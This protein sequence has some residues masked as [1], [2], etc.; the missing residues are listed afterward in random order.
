MQREINKDRILGVIM[1]AISLIFAY[2]TTGIKQT[3]MVGDPGPRLFP[4][5][6]CF[7]IGF[8]SLVLIIRKNRTPYKAYMTW[9]QWRRFGIL[10]GIYIVNYLALYFLGYKVAV[11]LTAGLTCFL[12]S[13]GS[14]VPTWKKILYII[15]VSVV[16]WLVYV[17]LLE[18]NLPAGKFR[19]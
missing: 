2:Y 11:P 12:F 1:L 15:G 9:Q 18:T 4:Y 7:F 19:L 10:F 8:F 17:K 14:G 16:L 5:I 6:A 13:K 3:N